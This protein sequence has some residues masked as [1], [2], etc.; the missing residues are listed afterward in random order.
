LWCTSNGEEAHVASAYALGG[1]PVSRRASR[2]GSSRNTS[3]FDFL[4]DDE[5]KEVVDFLDGAALGFLAE[6]GV[7]TGPLCGL[8]RRWWRRWRRNSTLS[9]AFAFLEP[10]DLGPVVAAYFAEDPPLAHA[11]H[12]A[13]C[14]KLRRLERASRS[15]LVDDL[16]R[17]L[18]I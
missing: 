12:V 1:S 11:A 17:S 5:V 3:R 14:D 13:S 6:S 9:A 15:A 16:S 10:G 4:G 8:L 18:F 2:A 7:V